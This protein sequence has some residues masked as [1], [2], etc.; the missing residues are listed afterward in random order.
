MRQ[1]SEESGFKASTGKYF[2]RPYLENVERKKGLVQEV[3]HMHRKFE[4]LS[5][6]PRNT[7]KI[8]KK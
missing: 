3:V 7:K 8:H 4:A 2:I 6:N 1:R 5:S